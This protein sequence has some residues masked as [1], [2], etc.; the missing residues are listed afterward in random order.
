MSAPPFFQSAGRGDLKSRVW[1]KDDG[2]TVLVWK[3]LSESEQ[4][5]LLKKMGKS[6]NWMVWCRSRLKW[7]R[8]RATPV[9][10][11]GRKNQVEADGR[12][13]F[14]NR[15]KQTN[16]KTGEKMDKKRGKGH[17]VCQ[18]GKR[19]TDRTT[20][21]AQSMHRVGFTKI[22]M[23]QT[24]EKQLWR[25]RPEYQSISRNILVEKAISDSKVGKEWSQRKKW[26]FLNW[27]NLY[28][29][30][31]K[32]TYQ[33]RRSTFDNSVRDAIRRRA[34]ENE[35]QKHT[36]EKRLTGTWRQ[37][38]PLRR[39]YEKWC[40]G[41]DIEDCT[42]KQRYEASY[43]SM[44][45]VLQQNTWIDDRKFLKSCVRA[46]LGQGKEISITLHIAR[47]RPTSYYPLHIKAIIIIT[48]KWKQ[49][50]LRKVFE[51]PARPLET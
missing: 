17:L 5:Q 9:E 32:V 48:A 30:A 11:D 41:D 27:E 8:R 23:W 36:R 39:R 28:C 38:S 49:S 31:G 37:M 25:K 45:K 7:N 29:E 2:P 43:Q 4:E 50:V 6:K 1:G 46:S 47:D 10:A 18:A 33:D 35:V 13:I 16:A 14:S 12:K 40:K 26:A 42:H 34:A 44:V 20:S 24:R 19:G 15:S 22:A 51:Q 3:T 21:N